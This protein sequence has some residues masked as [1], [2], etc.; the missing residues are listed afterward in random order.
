MPLFLALV[1]VV[2]V[3]YLSYLFSKYVA[4][5]AAKI[6]A[7]KYM[8]VIDRIALGQDKLI[9]ILQIGE[10]YFMTSVTSQS[11][12]ILKELTSEDLVDLRPNQVGGLQESFKHTLQNY[13]S[14]K[15]KV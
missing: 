1:A 9:V 15:D 3:I 14:K 8:K 5:G 6:N 13:L 2:V 11:V 7:A 4:V 12:Q 10:Q